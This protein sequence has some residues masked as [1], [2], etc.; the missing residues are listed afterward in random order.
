MD[1]IVMEIYPLA[2]GQLA[3]DVYLRLGFVVTEFEEVVMQLK[4]NIVSPP[5]QTDYGYMAVAQDPDGRK[6]ELY[7]KG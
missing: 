2:K 7:K 6:V 5:A 1:G 4:S 3:T